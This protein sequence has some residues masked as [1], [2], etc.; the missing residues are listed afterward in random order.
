MAKAAIV[1]GSDSDMPVMARPRTFL[2]NWV[3]ILRLRLFRLTESL[4]YSLIT[5]RQQRQEE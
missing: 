4:I 1:M 2:R 5:R 3:L